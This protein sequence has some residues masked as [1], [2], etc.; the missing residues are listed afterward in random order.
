[1]LR[2]KCS[3]CQDELELVHVDAGALASLAQD[4]A[5]GHGRVLARNQLIAR[6]RRDSRSA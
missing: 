6:F 5:E 4:H 2:W 3:D 1:M